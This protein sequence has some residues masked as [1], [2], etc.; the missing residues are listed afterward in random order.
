MSVNGKTYI[1]EDD[2]DELRTQPM[3]E[4]VPTLKSPPEK[5]I[6]VMVILDV[7]LCAR[8]I[9]EKRWSKHDILPK[10]PLFQVL[11]EKIDS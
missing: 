7:L 11:I 10:K 4:L 9:S 3:Y 2:P 5:L 8:K 1:N 6:D